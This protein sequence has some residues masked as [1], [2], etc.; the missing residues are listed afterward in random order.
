MTDKTNLVRRV[1]ELMLLSDCDVRT[2]VRI[3]SREIDVV[4]EERSGISRKNIFI[5]CADYAEPVGVAKLQTDLMKLRAAQEEYKYSSHIMHVASLGYTTDA[6]AYAQQNRIEAFAFNVLVSRLM[7]FDGYVEAIRSDPLRSVVLNEYQPTAIHTEGHPKDR[8]PALG[9]IK[10]WL[11]GDKAWLT[12]L[13][14]YGVGK[15]WML[16]RVLYQLIDDY[17]ADPINEPLPLFVPLQSF[18]KAFDFETLITATLQRSGV[19]TVNYKAFEKLAQWGRVTFLLDSFDEMA[20]VIR[21]DVIREN[22]ASLLI[23]V[24]NGSKAILTSRPTYFES[25]AE[26]LVVVEK[27]NSLVWE[28]L[29]RQVEEHRTQLAELLAERLSQT[30]YARLNDLTASQRQA[31]FKRV[32]AGKPRAL[33]QLNDL[34]QRFASLGGVS[35]RAVI[36]RLLTT[37]AETLADHSQSATA[38]GYKLIP[39]DVQHLNEAKIFEIVISNLLYR[40]LNFGGLTTAERRV[41]LRAFAVRLQQ[42]DRHLFAHPE[43]IRSLVSTLFRYSLDKSDTPQSDL[44]NYYRTC[45]RHSGLTTERQFMDTS[46]MI[47][48]PVEDSDFDS[49][50]GFSHNS[51]REFLVADSIAD[52]L[53]GGPMIDGLYT[54]R[55]TDAVSGFLDGLSEYNSDLRQLISNAY[56][57]ATGDNIRQ[58]YFRLMLGFLRSDPSIANLLGSPPIIRDLDLAGVDLSALRLA[59]ANLRGSLL[60][61]T[62]LRKADL[63]EAD[64]SGAILER[65][66]LD[67]AQ[68]A[69]ADFRAAEIVSIYVNDQFVR[70]TTAVLEGTEAIQWLFSSGALVPGSE[71]L[72][73]YLGQPWY[74]AAREVAVSLKSRLAGTHRK[75]GLTRGTR[76]IYRPLAVEF[77]DY[78]LKQGVLTVV[79]KNRSGGDIVVR[80]VPKYRT[81]ITDFADSGVISEDLQPFFRKFLDSPT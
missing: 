3:G 44:E 30:S 57:K 33:S 74:D 1:A 52:Y 21:P 40:D 50:V 20:Q 7:N 62:D 69:G 31:L 2:S 47:D 58:W 13:G 35:Q 80:V 17:V 61:E 27:N 59:H 68:L 60:L 38:D 10:S 63:R 67:H 6:N 51:L 14:D 15:S 79:R 24:S 23:G 16:K 39:D 11:M 12:V 41:F 42:P 45:R 78:L 76:M 43:E 81:Q 19:T 48:T 18:T 71:T 22:L 65:V 70:D 56:A 72:N 46:G 37:V 53:A 77:T 54:A 75:R 55:I 9:Y 4:A 32:L 5:E 25:R 29:D 34:H 26:R 28:Q 66:Q 8:K 73:P 49:P 64:F 36:A